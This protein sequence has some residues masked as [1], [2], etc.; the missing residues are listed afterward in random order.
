[1]IMSM[2]SSQNFINRHFPFL[3]EPL[4]LEMETDGVLKEFP[5]GTELLREGQYV[6][7]IPIVFD[8]LVK[9]MGRFDDKDLLLYYIR[10]KESCIMSFSAVLDNTPS[11]ILAI[12]EEATTALL[13]PS[14]SVEKWVRDFPAFNRLFYQQFNQRYEDM[15]Q[16]IRALF[17][18]RMDQRLLSYL[19]QK[20]ALKGNAVMTLRHW[21][22]AS[23]L[24][25]AREVI[26]RLLKKLETEGL[27]RQLPHG[28]I[29][30]CK[31]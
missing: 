9:V 12:T 10:P 17:Y 21:E 28:Q 30:V 6:K 25:S 4:R 20:A 13:L 24:G 14:P 19:R 2:N 23:D 15:L 16:T 1:M 26:S 29:E 18:E 8:G 27:I 22:I 11:K 3:P 31:W 5:A 7:V